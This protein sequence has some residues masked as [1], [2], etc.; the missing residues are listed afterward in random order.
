MGMANRRVVNIENRRVPAEWF[1][2]FSIVG[3]DPGRILSISYF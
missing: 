1:E 3:K 2:E